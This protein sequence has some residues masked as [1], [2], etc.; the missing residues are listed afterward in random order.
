MRQR[1]YAGYR[2]STARQMMSP[3]IFGYALGT[4]NPPPTLLILR[5]AQRSRQRV[6][7]SLQNVR[8]INF[9]VCAGG[10]R[11][12][13]IYIYTYTRENQFLS[14]KFGGLRQGM[15][16]YKIQDSED[17]LPQPFYFV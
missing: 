15:R 11:R 6:Q 14:E 7:A 2:R 16:L 3:A 5:L 12:I 13:Y 8:I 1:V 9:W 4:K 17:M 10:M